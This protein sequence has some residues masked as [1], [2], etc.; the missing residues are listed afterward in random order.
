MS[1]NLI[2]RLPRLLPLAIDWAQEMEAHCLAQGKPLAF[3]QDADAR[4]VGVT[5]P[6]R[7]RICL[8]DHVPKPNHPE[9]MAAA[10]EI[11]FLG[12]TLGYGIFI[13]NT[14]M[15]RRWLLRHELRHV[16]QCEKAGGLGS[17]LTE[18]LGQ[19]ANP[20]YDQAPMK[21]DARR[22]EQRSPGDPQKGKS[23]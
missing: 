14:H 5:T 19:V 13:R 21:I 4:D 16:A 15:G 22:F 8:V 1:G 11:D 7:V 12:L 20:G 9:L 23:S 6:A 2:D 3:W 18:Y 10:E 17:F